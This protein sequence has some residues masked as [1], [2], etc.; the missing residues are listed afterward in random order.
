MGMRLVGSCCHPK[1]A[2]RLVPLLL[3]LLCAADETS[4]LLMID[5]P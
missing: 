4:A 5:F 3:A 1:E 2:G